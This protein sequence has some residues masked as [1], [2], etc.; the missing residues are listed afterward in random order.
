LKRLT[1]GHILT[2][3]IIIGL[4]VSGI[5]PQA[6]RA[7]WLMEVLPVLILLPTT[8]V[9]Q[10]KLKLSV[11]T[12]RFMTL[13]AFV[14]MIGGYYTY[15]EVPAGEWVRDTLNLSRNPYDRLGH[16]MQGFVPALVYRELLIP[17]TNLKPG[18]LFNLIV[19]SFCLSF[20]ALYEMLEWAAAVSLGQGADAFLG[21]QGDQ[22]DTQWDMF[23]AL[24]GAIFALLAVNA[25]AG[26]NRLKSPAD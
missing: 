9:L 3:L 12:L 5:S 20:S 15:A 13:H 14:L 21:T 11:W 26:I 23:L 19:C 1:E 22:W 16:F 7:T 24:I 6:D 4:I 8:I 25:A 17:K 10:P 18:A 2:V